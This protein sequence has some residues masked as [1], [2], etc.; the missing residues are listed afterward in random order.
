MFGVFANKTCRP[1][2]V[3]PRHDSASFGC[4]FIV[5]HSVRITRK[6]LLDNILLARFRRSTDDLVTPINRIGS[7][8]NCIYHH[9]SKRL[10]SLLLPSAFAYLDSLQFAQP[11][12]H[13]QRAGYG[14]FV[15]HRNAIV[16]PVLHED[17][18]NAGLAVADADLAV[19]A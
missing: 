19:R 16:L 5:H 4:S 12:E 13:K 18:G 2:P 11:C 10:P 6:S 3:H 17:Y 1:S 14:F 9:T 15:F 7:R 8:E